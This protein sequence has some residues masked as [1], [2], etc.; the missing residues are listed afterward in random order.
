[1]KQYTVSFIGAGNVAGAL[2]R[3]FYDAG[4]KIGTIVSRSELKGTKLASDCGAKWQTEL[5]FRE[6]HDII[7]VAVPDDSIQDLLNG[8]DTEESTI[9]VHTAGSL[10]LEVFPSRFK[11]KGVFYPLQTFSGGRRI[12][13]NLLPIFLEAS[14]GTTLEV[15]RNLA[16]VTGGIVNLINEN[17]RLLLHVAAVFVN[18]FT[19][20][21]LTA[22]KTIT[23]KA[24]LSFSV[25]EPLIR[26][27][28]DKAIK[29]GPEKSQTGPAARNDKGTIEKHI[30]LLSFSADLQKV[31]LEVTKA[32]GTFSN[33]SGDDQL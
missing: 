32:I 2:C 9:I 6:F 14:D 30:N 12:E 31:Y 4:I 11:H 25:L 28:I 20:Y 1:M 33:D 24:G 7:I 21:M 26:E 23:D 8:I 15:L 18:N 16:E 3:R 29:K 19:N 22:G 17:Q 10:G 13:F 5:K 27:T